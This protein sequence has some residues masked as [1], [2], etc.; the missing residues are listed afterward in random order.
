[1]AVRQFDRALKLVAENTEAYPVFVRAVS[2]I[3]KRFPEETEEPGE[4]SEEAS[5]AFLEKEWKN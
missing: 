1:M 3:N 2:D 4:S 5:E